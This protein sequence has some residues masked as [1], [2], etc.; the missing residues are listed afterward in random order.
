MMGLT[1]LILENW[2]LPRET[3]NT[4]AMN[5]HKASAVLVDSVVCHLLLQIYCR[6]VP[7]IAFLDSKMYVPVCAAE[8]HRKQHKSWI[9]QRLMI[10]TYFRKHLMN[11][12]QQIYAP[13][14][15]TD[16]YRNRMKFQS[17][18]TWCKADRDGFERQGVHKWTV[19]WLKRN[20]S[21]TQNETINNMVSMLVLIEFKSW[22]KQ[23]KLTC[24]LQSGDLLALR[25]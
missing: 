18:D 17:N 16:W 11:R 20:V 9:R 19:E 2:L 4:Q 23:D 22:W 1:L 5:T 13:V 15:A 3:N 8:W 25:T 6:H 14:G 21:C 7:L 12:K 10:Q 24:L